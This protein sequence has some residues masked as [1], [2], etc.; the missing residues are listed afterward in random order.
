[1]DMNDYPHLWRPMYKIEDQPDED[2]EGEEWAEEQ[3]ELNSQFSD[4]EFDN[5]AYGIE[6]DI[7]EER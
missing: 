2:D 3:H 7:Y 5:D 1:M 4:G 6:A